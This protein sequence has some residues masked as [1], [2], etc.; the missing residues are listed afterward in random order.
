MQVEMPVGPR[1]AQVADHLAQHVRVERRL[2]IRP[3]PA[4][5]APSAGG[6]LHGAL[7][8]AEGEASEGHAVGRVEAAC[9]LHQ[10]DGA[11][12][13]G[14]LGAE[15]RP[16]VPRGHAPDHGQR[17]EDLFF[18]RAHAHSLHGF[19]HARPFL[20]DAA[21]GERVFRPACGTAARASASWVCACRSAGV[22]L[23]GVLALRWWVRGDDA[24]RAR[25]DHG[26]RLSVRQS[27]GRESV[28]SN[29][30]TAARVARSQEQN[31]L[32]E[33]AVMPGALGPS[34]PRSAR[35]GRTTRRWRDAPNGEDSGHLRTRSAPRWRPTVT[36]SGCHAFARD[37][38]KLGKIKDVIEAG[39]SSYLVIGR[40][41]SRDLLVPSASSKRSGERVEVPVQRVLPRHGSARESK[42]GGISPEER[43]R[44]ERF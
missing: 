26:S 25:C 14:V 42:G 6:V 20:R 28:L 37:G 24:V 44:L 13:Q 41:L 23:L 10:G 34:T 17:L 3:R 39:E 19:A 40:F 36:S 2:G 33:A 35:R 9:R 12:A 15:W 27:Q 38:T 5:A 4:G 21:T 29:Q 30:A 16:A 18:T 22:V 7:D 32:P 1:R 8:A 43:S 11:D 31:D